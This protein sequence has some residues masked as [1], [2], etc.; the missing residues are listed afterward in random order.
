M[1]CVAVGTADL[2][3]LYLK[4]ALKLDDTVEYPLH[5]VRVDEVT[6]GLH[7]FGDAAVTGI[8]WCCIQDSGVY[9]AA[10]SVK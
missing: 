8:H 3:F 7:H 10:R 1:R 5:N 6:L 9:D 2:K 4:A